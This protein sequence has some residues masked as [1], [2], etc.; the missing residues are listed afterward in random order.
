MK[1]DL[2]GRLTTPE[3]IRRFIEGGNATFTIKNPATGVRFTYRAKRPPLDP[4]STRGRPIWLALL[5]GPDN[6][7]NYSYIGA[8]Y[9]E[10]NVY[11]PIRRSSKSKVGPEAISAISLEWFLRNLDKLNGV[12]VWHEGRCG[13]C[14][15]KLTVP[16][17]VEAGFGPECSSILGI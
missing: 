6:E 16:E 9:A 12:E 5:S 2:V 10:G 7:S 11:S 1:H 3:S 14:G 15:R 4:Q 8:V 13:R 17:S